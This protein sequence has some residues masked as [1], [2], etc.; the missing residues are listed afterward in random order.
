M[1]I[2][3]LFMMVCL[4]LLLKAPMAFAEMDDPTRPYAINT[5]DKKTGP[6]D[7]MTILISKY[8]KLAIINNQMVKIGDYVGENQV[9]AI[10]PNTVQLEGRDGKIMLFLIANPVK[11]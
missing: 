3:I 2:R 4:S 6:L 11:R 1:M 5:Q 7:L 8:R 9:V 10:D